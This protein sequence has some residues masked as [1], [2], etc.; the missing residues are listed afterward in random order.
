MRCCPNDPK[1]KFM[2]EQ[3]LQ[4]EKEIA[5]ETLDRICA[6]LRVLANPTRFK[7]AYLLSKRDYCVCEIVYILNEKQNLV[8]HHLSIMK[9]NG[10][11]D[12]YKNSKWKYYRLNLDINL[13]LKTFEFYE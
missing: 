5:P 10:I 7:I 2:W 9:K 13:I 4:V 1:I 6:S 11:V 8:S 3:E 12:T